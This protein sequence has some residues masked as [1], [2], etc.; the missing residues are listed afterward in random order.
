MY[1]SNRY[2]FSKTFIHV[3]TFIESSMPFMSVPTETTTKILFPHV[4]LKIKLSNIIIIFS[5]KCQ[6]CFLQDITVKQ[7]WS[8][9]SWLI[10][11]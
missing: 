1:D 8:V 6:K 2:I 9:F 7:E 10:I 4:I 11:L 3:E 5:K